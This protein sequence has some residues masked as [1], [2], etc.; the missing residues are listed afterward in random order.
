MRCGILR[1]NSAYRDLLSNDLGAIG[2]LLFDIGTGRYAAPPLDNDAT[3]LA[4][5]LSE[6]KRAR[7]ENAAASK[8][9]KT[10]QQ[11]ELTHKQIQGWLRDLGH[12]LGFNVWIAAND[13]NR[14]W[15]GGQL[16]D[17]CLDALPHGVACV[18]GAEA[19]RLIDVLWLDTDSGQVAAGFEVEHTTSIYSGTMRLLDLALGAPDQAEIPG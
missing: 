15:A 8:A 16:G 12:A 17:G 10:A 5:W 1:L 7:E 19:V 18:R 9:M 14:P 3:A 4:T 11:N 2:G 6:L 13:R